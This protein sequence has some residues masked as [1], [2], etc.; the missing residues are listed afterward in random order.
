MVVE[1]QLFFRS[2]YKTSEDK[3]SKPWNVPTTERPLHK[4]PPIK[5]PNPKTFRLQNIPGLKTSQP[6]ELQNVPTLKRPKPQNV[7]AYYGKICIFY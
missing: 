1:E 6:H 4:V 2:S 3:T 7:P 5:C